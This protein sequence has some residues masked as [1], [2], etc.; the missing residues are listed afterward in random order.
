MNANDVQTLTGSEESFD[1]LMSDVK[2]GLEIVEKV[3]F[4]DGLFSENT[5]VKS[6]KIEEHNAPT[7]S[8]TVK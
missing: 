3:K 8:K 4:S 6:D 2:V 7:V 5:S 1:K